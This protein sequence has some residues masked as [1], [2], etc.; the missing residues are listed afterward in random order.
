MK[1][2]SIKDFPEAG[3]LIRDN[4]KY[5]IY[6]ISF[7]NWRIS[8]TK[9]HPKQSTTGHSHKES[10]EIYFFVDGNG[11]IQGDNET[12]EVKKDDIILIPRGEFHKVF[13]ESDEELVF[14][15]VFEKYEGR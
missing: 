8:M 9:L 2:I 10:L 14:I 13:N 15:C 3:N 6:D 1:K 7:D 4:E 5:K 11:K 12:I